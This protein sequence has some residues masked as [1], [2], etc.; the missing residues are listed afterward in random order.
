MMY[1]FCFIFYSSQIGMNR[2]LSIGN[3]LAPDHLTASFQLIHVQPTSFMFCCPVLYV[4]INIYINIYKMKFC[5]LYTCDI[6]VF[7]MQTKTISLHSIWTKMLDIQ[8]PAYCGGC[9]SHSHHWLQLSRICN[10][11]FK[12]WSLWEIVP[13]LSLQNK[14]NKILLV[15]NY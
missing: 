12:Y 8:V 11:I 14:R 13:S 10:A 3:A 9:T 5:Y 15:N 7:H 1:S 4:L 2:N 6:Y